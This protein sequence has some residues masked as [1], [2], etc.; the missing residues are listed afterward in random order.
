MGV[1]AGLG[2]PGIGYVLKVNEEGVTNTESAYHEKKTAEGFSGDAIWKIAST[3]NTKWR[4]APWLKDSV[5]EL[6]RG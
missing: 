2:N 6:P 5:N 1:R 3:E 4:E